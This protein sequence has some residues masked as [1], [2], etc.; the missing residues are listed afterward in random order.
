MKRNLS[1]ELLKVLDASQPSPSS[2]SDY[3]SP[4]L[5]RP[6]EIRGR[7]LSSGTELTFAYIG[8]I[9]SI[10]V[11]RRAGTGQIEY[12]GVGVKNIGIDVLDL[13]YSVEGLTLNAICDDVGY[14]TD[15]FLLD[16]FN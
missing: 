10:C 16:E 6:V 12:I 8:S 15:A 9:S 11:W 5:E 14:E 13:R 7:K 3:L 4:L 1:D 2:E